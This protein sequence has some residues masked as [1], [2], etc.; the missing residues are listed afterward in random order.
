M[1]GL[2]FGI[3]FCLQLGRLEAAR[4]GRGAVVVYARRLAVLLG[5]GLVHAALL[6]SGDVLV[7][8]AV[9]G[10]GLLAIRRWSDRAVLALLLACLLLPA[11]AEALRP[12]VLSISTEAIGAFEMEDYVQS[13]DAAFGRGSFIDAVGETMRV[14]AWYYSSSLGAFALAVFY[15]QMATGILLGFLVGRRHWV[16]RL[17]ALR[18]QVHRAQLAALGIALLAA[19]L[20]LV[21]S[22]LGPHLAA[23]G[24]ESLALGA[25]FLDTLVRSVGRPALMAFY[26]LTLLRLLERPAAARWLRPFALAGRMPLSNY[27]LQSLLGLVV[28]YGW[29]FGF[30]NRATPWMEV[31]LAAA[32]YF[33]VQLPLSAWWLSRFRYGP[34]EYVWRRLTY[35]R[36]TA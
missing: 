2:L 36:L 1:F 22:S 6:W 15:V 13:N 30:W 35:G 9:L 32:I 7:V 33:V 16:E 34:V 14:F 27:L 24:A 19:A 25:N 3:G 10:F 31:A 20:S 12:R 17:P 5:I 29:G 11:V 8:Y 28:F 23:R 21:F 26:A 4:P 18:P